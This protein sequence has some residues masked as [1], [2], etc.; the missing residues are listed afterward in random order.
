MNMRHICILF[1][2]CCLAFLNISVIAAQ[3]Q[4][5]NQWEET[6]QVFE[7][8]DRKNSFPSDAVLFTGS[9][10][11]RM[12]PTRECFGQIDVINRGFGGFQISDVIYFT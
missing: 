12:W 2:S 4:Q 7:E 3:E 8:W 10:S 11:I 1:I 6:I 9:S 5:Q